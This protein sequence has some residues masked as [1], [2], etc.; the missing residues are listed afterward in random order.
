MGKDGKRKDWIVDD[1]FLTGKREEPWM[2]SLVVKYHRTIEEYF[3]LLVQAGLAV[4]RL[5]EASPEASSF[6]EKTEYERRKR[7]PLFL[8][9]S[10][11]KA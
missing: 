4:E 11:R 8:L 9:F 2:G 6:R 7:I 3:T 1:Y 10:C 5:K